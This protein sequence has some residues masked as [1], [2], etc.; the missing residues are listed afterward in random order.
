MTANEE[1]ERETERV[2]DHAQQMLEALLSLYENH[3][4]AEPRRASKAW[5]EAKRLLKKLGRI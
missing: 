4:P 1:R 5:N 3:M 2:K